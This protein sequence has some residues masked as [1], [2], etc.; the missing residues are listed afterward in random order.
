[1]ATLRVD[2][3]KCCGCRICEMACSMAHHGLFN[4][5]K[6]F[7][8]IEMNRLPMLGTKIS[9]IDVPV[10]CL[11]CD[12]APCSEVCPER[13][14]ERTETG[15]WIVD[16]RK[17]SGCGFCVDA[18]SYGMITVNAQEN[19]AGKCDLCEGRPLCVAYCPT[20]ALIF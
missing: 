5:R 13:A 8:R 16:E 7:L 6:A 19:S 2:P 11:Q 12:S 15:A 4:P 10:V 17:C 3:E 1:M 9:E 14:I 20:G 18:C